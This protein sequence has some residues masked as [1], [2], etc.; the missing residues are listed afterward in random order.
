MTNVSASQPWNPGPLTPVT[1]NLF[2]VHSEIGFVRGDAAAT[3][4]HDARHPPD[5]AVT[6]NVKY[7]PINPVHCLPDLFQHHHMSAALRFQPRPTHLPNTT[8]V[9]SS[10]I[11]LPPSPTL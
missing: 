4:K 8:H 11:L 9:I 5:F 2:F 1:C 6:G 3:A 10:S 7:R